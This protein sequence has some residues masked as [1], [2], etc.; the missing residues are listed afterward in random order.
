MNVFHDYTKET[1]CV[2]YVCFTAATV[3]L[4]LLLHLFSRHCCVSSC[5]CSR[6]NRTANC[7]NHSWELPTRRWS[8]KYRNVQKKHGHVTAHLCDRNASINNRERS[9]TTLKHE[10]LVDISFTKNHLLSEKED[11]HRI[12]HRSLHTTYSIYI[13]SLRSKISAIILYLV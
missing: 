2:S 5:N 10:Y 1:S 8:T 9:M 12:P 7:S 4:A 6:M 3:F 13:Y 11:N